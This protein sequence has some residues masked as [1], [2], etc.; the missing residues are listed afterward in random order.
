MLVYLLGVVHA[1]GAGTDAST[2][3]L[4]AFLLVTGVP[5]V[6]LFLHRIRTRRPVRAMRPAAELPVGP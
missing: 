5:I 3:W 6:V 2:P 4:R 1:V